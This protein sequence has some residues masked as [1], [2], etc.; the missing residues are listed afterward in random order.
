MTC[1]N[2]A[3]LVVGASS[4]LTISTSV[5][6][7]PGQTITNTANVERWRIG[8]DVGFVVIGHGAGGPARHHDAAASDWPA[9]DGW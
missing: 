6:A 9:G 1:V 2:A 3:T 7:A 8:D 5:L 4:T